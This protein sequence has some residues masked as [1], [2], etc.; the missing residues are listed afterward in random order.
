MTVILIVSLLLLTLVG[1]ASGVIFVQMRA[2]I[3]EQKNYERGLKMVPLLIHLPPPSEDIESNGRDIRELIDENISKAQ[4]IYNI[5]ASTVQKGFKARLHGQ[6]HFGFEIVGAKGF[7]HFYAAVPLVLVEVVKQAIVSAYPSARL[8]EVAE[9]NI[10]SPIGKTSGTVG[11]ELS[12]KESFAYPIATYQDL[13]RDAMQALLNALST[14]E[15]DDGAGIQIVLRPADPSWR[16]EALGIASKKRKG[17]DAKK[18]SEHLLNLGKDFA[19]AF[20]KPPE[21]REDKGSSKNDLSSLE[22]AVLD[23]IEDKTRYPGYEVLI[24]VV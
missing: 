13:K 2:K 16:K 5:I 4:V 18:S 11:G 17:N 1:A 24:R 22:Q 8:E 19:T 21:N 7:V 20:V 23:S 15:K 10:F 14:L 12:L 3:Q 6:R 9:H